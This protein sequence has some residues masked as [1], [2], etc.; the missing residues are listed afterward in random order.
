MGVGEPWLGP[1]RIVQGER[2]AICGDRRP[3]REVCEAAWRLH[4]LYQREWLQI[5]RILT[6][7]KALPPPASGRRPG[8]ADSA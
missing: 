2:V 3:C 7:G 6:E 1:V 4:K 8:L 5:R